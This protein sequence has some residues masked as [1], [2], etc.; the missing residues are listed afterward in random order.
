MATEKQKANLKPIEELNASLTREQRQQNAIKAGQ[1]S[2]KK[3]RD[4]RTLR[5][6]MLD[7][8]AQEA[9]AEDQQ[10]YNLPEGSSNSVVMSAA[11]FNKARNGDLKALE[12]VRDTAGQM[13]TKEVNLSAEVITDADK[14]L[15][16]TVSKRLQKE[17]KD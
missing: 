1:A 13:P 3:K 4:T 2:A 8:L 16:E 10:K 12:I 5:E 15:L 11:A 7:M 6:I 17:I 14:A 9:P